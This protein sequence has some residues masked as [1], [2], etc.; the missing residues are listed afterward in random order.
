MPDSPETWR[1]FVAVPV[2]DDLRVGLATAL[3]RWKLERDAPD[4]R[5]TDPEGWH[6]TLAFLGATDP[7]TVDDLRRGLESVTRQFTSPFSPILV[8]TGPIGAF[9]RAAAAQSVWL[10][11]DDPLR[12]LKDLAY[13]VQTAILAQEKWRR[14]RPHL[15]LGRSRVRRGEPLE[16]W[17]ATRT[18]PPTE[19][20]VEDVVLFRSHLGRGPAR[21]EELARLPLGGAGSGRG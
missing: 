14:L 16:S 6:V 17:I 5:W 18:F 1:C 11:I 8:R 20:P 19:F 13:A 3:D 21:Y 2:P 7:A 4:L 9:P 10:G 12:Q 15:T